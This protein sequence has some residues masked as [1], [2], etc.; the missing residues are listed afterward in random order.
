MFESSTVNWDGLKL[1]QASTFPVDTNHTTTLSILEAPPTPGTNRT[2]AVRVP[3]W[4]DGANSVAV[5]GE[6]VPVA[7]LEPS[8]YLLISRVFKLGDKV[9]VHY[10]MALR[11]ENVDDA[12]PLYANGYGAIMCTHT[13]NLPLCAVIVPLDR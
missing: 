9:V 8:T 11:F 5:N 6:V 3:W 2:I 12:R 10:P 1:Q 7:Q 4:A 13:R